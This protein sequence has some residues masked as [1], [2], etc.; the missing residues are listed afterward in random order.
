MKFN[1][2]SQSFADYVHGINKICMRLLIMTFFIGV[3]AL[4][5]VAIM[6]LTDKANGI[7]VIE[8][9]VASILGYIFRSVCITEFFLL[10]FD[11]ASKT[12]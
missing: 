4:L 3:I 5:G 11:Y 9:E 7:S 8:S 2:T 12:V 1:R 10:L 6:I